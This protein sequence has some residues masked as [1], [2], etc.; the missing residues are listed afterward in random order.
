MQKVQD[1]SPEVAKMAVY[2]PVIA[3]LMG[4]TAT[5]RDAGGTYLPRESRE[6]QEDWEYRRC[7]ATLLP[8]F[9]RTVQVMTGKPFS[10]P[11][12]LSE[13]VPQVILSGFEDC[14]MQG[15]NLHS[16][17]AEVMNDALAYGL[18]GVLVDFPK[19]EGQ[20]RTLADE[21]S[22]GARPYLVH[23]KHD[24]ILG[25]KSMRVNGVMMLTQLR[26]MESADQDD[27]EY[28]YKEVQ[29]VRVLTP[30]AYQLFEKVKDEYQLIDQGTT[31]LD[32][33]PFV[34][35]YGRKIGYMCAM[36]PLLDLAYLNVKHWQH[37]SDQDDSARFARK[38]ILAFIGMDNGT[39]V[40]ASSHY[41]IDLPLGG[42]VKVV[43]GSAESVTTGRTELQALEQQMIM[44]GAEMLQPRADRY[45][46]TA[47]QSI[48]EDEAN[49]CELQRI[50]EQ[51]EDGLDQIIALQCKWLNIPEA[52][53]AT[54][55]KDFA[56]NSLTDASAQLVLSMQQ[57]GL[58]SK[59]TAIKE[60]QRRGILSADIDPEIE[61]DGVE[62]DGPSL[63]LMS[64]EGQ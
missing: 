40:V 12:T 35:F 22:L 20:V 13:D 29:R 5:M 64:N 56:A 49:K 37:Q 3:A 1:Q 42:D 50:T 60:Q 23:I 63:G 10:K 51:F 41:G 14:D 59:Q 44:T 19:T 18:S 52:G 7:T 48:S 11:I 54:L 32:V 6:S 45:Q 36:P 61:L 38:R 34:P 43:Q 62:E 9:K 15:N 30:G 25:W 31:T 58:I 53:S 24:Q 39:K 21:R 27:G 4:G 26:L 57:G 47:T 33:I 16:F 2:W 17:S 46:K 55:F 28:G 8:A